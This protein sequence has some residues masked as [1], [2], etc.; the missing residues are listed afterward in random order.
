MYVNLFYISCTLFSRFKVNNSAEILVLAVEVEVTS[1]AGLH[2]GGNSGI[3]NFGMGGSLQTPIHYQISLKNSAKKPVKVLVS[4]S[5]QLIYS[6]FRNSLSFK[7]GRLKFG[8]YKVLVHFE[9]MICSTR[10]V[11][12][13]LENYLRFFSLFFIFS[14]F[15]SLFSIAVFFI[16]V[17][18]VA[19][20]R[21]QY[22]T[23]FFITPQSKIRL[24]MPVKRV[25]NRVFYSREESD[26][27]MQMAVS[28]FTLAHLHMLH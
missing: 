27:S 20:D 28:F 21:I 16:S 8:M 10:G 3:V 19:S 11:P 17:G 25:E 23:I 13:F 6:T 12:Y 7:I 22:F 15:S 26:R 9:I 5:F 4:L 24:S 14:T 18:L 2:W 1:V